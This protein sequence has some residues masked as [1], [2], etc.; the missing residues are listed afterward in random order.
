MIGVI[1]GVLVG[2]A[3]MST[4]VSY[5]LDMYINEITLLKNTIQDKNARLEKLEESINTTK[6]ILKDIEVV[7]IM[8][9]GEN[10][11]VHKIDIEKNIKEKYT[12]LLGKEVKN[13]DAEM[14][15]EVID[16]RI[17]KIEDSEYKLRIDKI[18][19]TEILRLWVNVEKIK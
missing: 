8:E 19:L 13:I 18:I 9:A 3:A 14:V 2:I 1:T 11:G 16:K 10:N 7:L 12:S 6:F 4:L 17:F 15:A 5:R